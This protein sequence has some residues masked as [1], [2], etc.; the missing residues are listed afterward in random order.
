[1]R[2]FSSALV[3]AVTG[4]WAARIAWLVVALAGIWSIGEALDGRS[5]AL[6][7]TVT[8]AAWLGWGVGVVA[9]MV[10]STLGLTT[11]R[12][13]AALAVCASVV[14]WVAGAN[15]AA[16]AVFV[17]SALVSALVIGS[18]DFGQR[19]V[20]ASAYGDEDRFLLRAPAA[21]LP[22]VAVAGVVWA[23]A[24]LAAPLLLATG[25]WIL[26]ILAAL[27]GGMLTVAVVPR[28]NLLSQRWLVLVP[29]GLVVHDPV[30][31]AETLVVPRSDVDGIELALAGTEAAD[32]TGP[33]GGHAIEI[34]LTSMTDA[35]LAPTKQ[36]P[37][38]TALH[39]RSFLVA[40]TRPGAVMR[41]AQRRFQRAMP[42]PST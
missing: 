25:Q 3:S 10:P 26:G 5:D 22:P 21:F 28:F 40:P 12:M 19:C 32:F 9:L 20:Q 30:V 2:S 34:S 7:V 39:V 14:S 23:A 13:V 24:V 38:G 6:R 37:R 41:A 29:A 33:A 31:L 18:A 36:S 35:L 16:G 4:P 42:P 15:A 11:A 1:M 17:A 8:A 27:V